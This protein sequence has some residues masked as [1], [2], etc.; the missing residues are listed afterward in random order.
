MA[1]HDVDHEL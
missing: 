1:Q